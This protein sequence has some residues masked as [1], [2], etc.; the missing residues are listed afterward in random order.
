MDYVQK[1][2]LDFFGT[3]YFKL[4]KDRVYVRYSNLRS[5]SYTTYDFSNINP[6]Y[7]EMRQATAGW[8]NVTWTVLILYFI[9][10]FIN[11]AF[12]IV[13]PRFVFFPFIFLLLLSL[14][15]SF[16]KKLF[17]NY[18]D[19][20]GTHLFSIRIDNNNSSVAGFLAKLNE[21]ILSSSPEQE[22]E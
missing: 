7:R 10:M 5:D 18:H 1:F 2:P 8:V 9:W 3:Q 20:Y 21:R 13:D 6:N 12:H 14:S 4:E 22:E 15:L 17:Y 19:Y 11:D 16:W